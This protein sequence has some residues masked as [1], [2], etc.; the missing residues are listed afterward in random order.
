MESFLGN[1][2]KFS[3]V[4]MI[5]YPRRGIYALAFKTKE[6]PSLPNKNGKLISVFLPTTPNPI[7]GFHLML[8]ENDIIDTDMTP[9]EAFKLILSAGIITPNETPNE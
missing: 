6:A 9:E 5:E 1:S 8:P 7:G 3:K 2:A 4:V